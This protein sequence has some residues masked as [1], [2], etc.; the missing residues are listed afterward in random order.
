MARLELLET[1]IAA[2]GGEARWKAAQGL[3]ATMRYGGLAPAQFPAQLPLRHVH[4]RTSLHVPRVTMAPYPHPGQRGLFHGDDVRIVSDAGPILAERT[5]PRRAMAQAGKSLHWDAL[6]ML[7]YI[8][9]AFWN[10]MSVPFLLS[11]P[12]FELEEL[13]P[14]GANRR[15]RARFPDWLPTHCREQVFHFGPEGRL[16]RHDFVP[17][18]IGGFRVA[19]TCEGYVEA[20]GILVPTRIRAHLRDRA[21]RPRP[22]PAVAWIDLADVALI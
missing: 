1:A 13:P 11:R 19:R 18:R 14:A 5:D 7:Y 10:Y 22:W 2:H 16:C 6:D 9:Y 15:L 20:G 8:S 3:V 17:E 21:D 12:G 4:V